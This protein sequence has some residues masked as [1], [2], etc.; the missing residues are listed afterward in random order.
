MDWSGLVSLLLH[1][2]TVSL[3]FC[4]ALY[5]NIES[6][7]MNPKWYSQQRLLLIKSALI[8]LR[9]SRLNATWKLQSDVLKGMQVTGS[10]YASF[11]ILKEKKVNFKQM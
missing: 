7:L 2:A 11:I 9:G 6:V 4:N 8:W 1:R 10:L 3:R 5:W